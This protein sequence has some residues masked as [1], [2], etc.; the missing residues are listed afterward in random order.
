VLVSDFDGDGWPDVYVANDK[1]AS[2][3]FHNNRDGTFEETGVFAGCAY[4]PDGKATSG[5]GVAAG[6]F[7]RDGWLD[8]LKTNFSDESTSL[9]HNTGSGVFVDN[10]L[11]TGLGRDRRW[12]GWGC[13]FADFDNDGWP[14]IL[15][16]NGH[17]FPELDGAGL[18]STFL[19]PRVLYRNLRGQRFE[20]VSARAGPAITTP[21][22]GRG[23]AFGDFDNDGQVDVVVNN[24]NEAPSLL[25]GQTRNENHWVLVDLQG[26]ESNRS[27][28]GARVACITGSLRQIDEVRSGGSF[29]SQ[30]D[31]RLH[32]GLGGAR[33]VDL[34]EIRWPSGGV[35]RIRD[36]D[37]DRILTVKEGSG[38]ASVRGVRR[39]SRP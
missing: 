18:G 13:G 20:D 32:F 11:R 12:V 27:A 7:D 37:A 30:S 19:Q 23:A 3:L 33:R 29:L 1:S 35:E 15:L 8:I 36:C 31:F 2:L 22:A 14:D 9:Y 6:D 4:D 39:S 26:V 17:V 38:I 5:M 24:M 21:A 25:R 34:L 28:I 16:V 10:T